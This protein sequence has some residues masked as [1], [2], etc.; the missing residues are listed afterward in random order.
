[1]YY[2]GRRGGDVELRGDGVG[3]VSFCFFNIKLGSFRIFWNDYSLLVDNNIR[4]F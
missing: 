3:L 1:M 4:V 2:G